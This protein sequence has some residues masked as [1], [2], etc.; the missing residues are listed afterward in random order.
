VTATITTPRARMPVPEVPVGSALR[1]PQFLRYLTGQ[2]ASG[3]GDQVWYV[4]MS[5]SAVRLGS[6]GA[7][8]IVLTLASLPRLALLLF[9]G[10]IADRFDI[11]RL[12][13]GTDV[14]RT[15][16]T[17][18]AAAI[19]LAVSGFGL[20]VVVTLVYGAV[21]GV[22]MP[23]AG[24]MQ[25]RLLRPEQYTSGAVASSVLARLA[26]ALGA[27][28]GGVMVAV[29][30][31]PLAL[32]VNGVTFAV[33]VATLATVRPRPLAAA[34]A[35][36][37]SDGDGHGVGAG[38]RGSVYL[39]D[40]ILGARFLMHQPV[41]GPL[42]AVGLLANLGFVGPMNIGIAELSE[43]RGWGAG[44]IGLLLTGFGV[45]AAAS[46]LLLLRWKIRRGAGIWISALC[47]VSGAALLAMALAPDLGAAVAATA[48]LGLVS[49]PMAVS[50][51]VLAQQHSPDELRGR[52]SSFNL[53]SSYGTVPVASIGTGLAIAAVGVTATFAVCGA[54]ESAALLWLLAPGL[55][56]ASITS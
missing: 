3:L 41:L 19:A 39:R 31:L 34:A 40:L 26:L 32:A 49:G 51:T 36:S 22:F 16:I 8:A 14:L 11:R 50:S 24:A 6:P 35:D 53:L 30:G 27:P 37:D 10:V 44:G 15:L 9:G 13:L 47:A 54:I 7:A 48:A 43:Q 38:G 2:A 23:A 33:S 17:F 12:M 28:V 21:D 45:G 20:L 55:R 1:D 18:T 4:A 56:A 25:P 52:L 5:W 46:A 42:T 29:G